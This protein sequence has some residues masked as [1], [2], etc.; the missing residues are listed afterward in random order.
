MA[1]YTLE[2]MNTLLADNVA[3]AITPAHIRQLMINF[4]LVYGT[5]GLVNGSTP[6]TLPN[7]D[8]NKVIDLTAEGQARGVTLDGGAQ[9]ITVP[10]A[11]VY[12][13]SYLLNF[14]AIAAG[15]YETAIYKNGSIIA[16][17]RLVFT[18]TQKLVVYP[19]AFLPLATND[20]IELFIKGPA[21]N[22]LTLLSGG[23]AVERKD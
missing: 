18:E 9:R 12:K 7:T 16:A 21:G 6:R 17:T 1:Y 5:I 4:N 23:L 2:E 3:A 20:Y 14:S 19:A 10:A 15:E 11:G 8:Y 22:Q 13:L